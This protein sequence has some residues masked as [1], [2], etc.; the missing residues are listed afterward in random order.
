MQSVGSYLFPCR[1]KSA[2]QQIDDWLAAIAA[3]NIKLTSLWL[4]IETDPSTGCGYSTNLTVNCQ[5]MRELSEALDNN[6]VK[7]WGVYSTIGEWS[8][9]FG[10]NCE[11]PVW[12]TRP[13]WYANPDNRTSFADFRAF[14]G[15]SAPFAKQYLWTDNPCGVNVDSDW[16]PGPFLLPGQKEG[17][18]MFGKPL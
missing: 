9:L 13:L 15:W 5:F 11:D 12:S 16:L 2:S 7:Y 4:D 14:G 10:N 18:D 8:Q 3:N 17:E 6:G 1:T